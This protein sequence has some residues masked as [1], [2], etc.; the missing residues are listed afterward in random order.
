M[1]LAIGLAGLLSDAVLKPSFQRARPFVASTDIRVI[2][3][4]PITNSFPSGHA[5][6]AFAGGLALG[7]IWPGA[8][9]ALWTLAGLVAFSRVYVGVHYPLDILG[10]ALVG[11]AAAAFVIGGTRWPDVEVAR[12]RVAA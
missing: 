8:R 4:R 7:R 10:G 1:A 3:T 12:R 2:A 11:L 5:A 9:V 6:T